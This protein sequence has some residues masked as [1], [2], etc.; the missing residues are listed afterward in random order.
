MGAVATRRGR[1]VA[2]VSDSHPGEEPKE[3]RPLPEGVALSVEMLPAAFGDCLVVRGPTGDGEFR[4]VVDTGPDD[5]CLAALSSRLALVPQ[6]GGRRRVD[7]FVVT[8]I[9]HDHI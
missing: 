9:D 1:R 3:E 6:I 7:L 8:H 2:A 4:M 5:G